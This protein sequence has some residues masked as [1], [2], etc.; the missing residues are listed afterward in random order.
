MV[1]RHIRARR[2]VIALAALA[3]LGLAIAGC[4]A[5]VR[6][7]FV[8]R[9]VAL[10]SPAPSDVTPG[11][12]AAGDAH[13]IDTSTSTPV[14]R[15]TILAYA[16]EHAPALIVA[17]S[18]RAVADAVLAEAAPLLP[19]NPQ[20]QFQAG[21]R[22][23]PG[24]TDLDLSA[25]LTQ[26]FSISGARGARMQASERFRELT[27]AEIE[28][29]RWLVR[30]GVHAAYDAALV[31]RERAQLAAQALTFQETTLGVVKR[32]IVAGQS[33]P[34]SER[35]AEAEVV[36]ARQ[37]ALAAEQGYLAARL[38]LAE[39]S[40]WPVANPPVLEGTLSAPCD[41]APLEALLAKAREHL[42][43]FRTSDAA[44][45]AAEA[46]AGAEERRAW[47]EPTVGVQV[48]REGS[49]AR[50]P[51]AT[52][53]QGIVSVPLPVWQRNQG[54][55]ARARA[56]A[57]VAAAQ[58]TS[59]E[60]VLIAQIARNL[61]EIATAA[62]RVRSYGAGI[63]PRFDEN[64]RLVRRAFEL[65][66]VD[67]LE[68]SV[69]RERFFRIQLDALGAQADYFAALAALERSVGVDLCRSTAHHQ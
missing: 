3:G 65:G 26:Q 62:A 35:L 33:S 50:E 45:R 57:E 13:L 69:A 40:G 44:V 27:E 25:M 66:E 46:R 1:S 39:L 5:G 48:S 30:C 34:M 31:A 28:E 18:R 59:G 4:T 68:V 63:L 19:E 67:L 9:T 60:S 21:P 58:K 15:A 14:D 20:F 22:L 42:P 52:I 36:Q 29:V 41:V 47:P 51:A 24:A 12:R 8:G 49:V 43:T 2:S 55:I 61:S 56:D 16:D 11:A 53:V 37:Q 23:G 64:L 17:R 10:S 38:A 6:P 7:P 32:Q 54:A